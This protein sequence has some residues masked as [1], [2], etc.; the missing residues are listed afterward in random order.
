MDDLDIDEMRIYYASHRNKIVVLNPDMIE[1]E[2]LNLYNINGQSVYENARLWTESYNEFDTPSL[3]TGVYIIELKTQR[4]V[5][6]KK[7]VIK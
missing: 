3:S 1:L 5:V 7:I 2:Q 6:S 4:G